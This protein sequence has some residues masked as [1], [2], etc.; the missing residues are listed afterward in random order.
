MK[1]SYYF[2][3]LNFTTVGFIFVIPNVFLLIYGF[4]FPF[5]TEIYCFSNEFDFVMT[6]ESTLLTKFVKRYIYRNFFIYCFD[7]FF[8]N[9]FC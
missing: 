5:M 9:M 6:K 2:F 3:D 4:F 1:Y 8:K 7:K